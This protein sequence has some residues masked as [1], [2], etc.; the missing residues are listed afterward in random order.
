MTR[1]PELPEHKLPEL[2]QPSPLD[3]IANPLPA[4]QWAHPI[5]YPWTHDCR[6]DCDLSPDWP[7]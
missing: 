6:T 4:P 5:R 3:Q 2:L 7:W 1:E